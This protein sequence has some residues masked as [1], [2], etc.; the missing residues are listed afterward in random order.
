[1]LLDPEK[2]KPAEGVTPEQVAKMQEEMEGLQKELKSVEESHGTEALNFVLAR[3][4]LSK[5]FSNA[6][7]TH[8]LGQHHADLFG[9]LQNILAGATL[10]NS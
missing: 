9:E 6:R 4:Y 10:D 8:Y 2:H 3:G 1:M 7:I 5:I